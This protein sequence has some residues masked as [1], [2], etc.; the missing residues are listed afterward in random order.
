VSGTRTGVS[1]YRIGVRRTDPSV[2]LANQGLSHGSG[3]GIPPLTAHVFP[4]PLTL[5]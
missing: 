1:R 3:V 4:F 2:S 5:V